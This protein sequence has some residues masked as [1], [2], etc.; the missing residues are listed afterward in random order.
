V[1]CDTYVELSVG[2][3]QRTPERVNS[4]VR[5]GDN[6]DRHAARWIGFQNWWRNFF[7][8]SLSTADAAE[9]GKGEPGGVPRVGNKPVEAMTEDFLKAWLLEGNIRE[10]MN[11][12]SPR[13]YA[14]MAEEADDPS[15]FDRGMAPFVLAHRLKASHDAVGARTSLEGL[16][17]GVRLTT[18]G[19]RL[20][21]QAHHAQYVV[22]AVPDDLAAVFDCE[23]SSL[24]ARS[25]GARRAY[26]NYFG[27][28]FYIKGPASATSL[29]MLW[30]RERG[31]WQANRLTERRRSRC[32]RLLAN[33]EFATANSS[34]HDPRRVAR[35]FL[36]LAGSQ[37]LRQGVRLSLTGKLFRA[38]A[39][40]RS[41]QPPATSLRDAGRKI[42]ERSR[43]QATRSGAPT[44]WK[45][46]SPPLRPFIRQS[47]RWI[48]ATAVPSRFPVF[49]TR[50][51]R[52]STATRAQKATPPSATGRLPT[53]QVSR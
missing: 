52:R 2:D 31:Y 49:P 39:T 8:V 44:G 7:G 3:V 35:G 11:Y 48:T 27:A 53:E 51:S 38:T 26:G 1:R 13:A 32:Q 40:R 21:K 16:T 24:L 4:D 5:A 15:T 20:V 10:A 23:S 28:T 33:D 45:V 25:A 18:P 42:R 29:A 6:A 9:P 41:D 12:V 50:W 14:C 46:S 22:Y 30:G 17:V 34:R 36:E 37:G 47:A 19:L 43:N